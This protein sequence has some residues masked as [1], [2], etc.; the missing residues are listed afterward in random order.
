MTSP[1]D[2]AEPEPD[3]LADLDELAATAPDLHDDAVALRP[4]TF[5]DVEAITAACQDPEIQ[6][7]TTVPSPYGLDDARGFVDLCRLAW[8]EALAA[9]FL[10][11]RADDPTV[12]LGAIDL[13]HTGPV[14]AEVGYWVAPR[15]RRQGVARRAMVLLCD[16]AFA[17]LDKHVLTLQVYDGND[18]S[19]AV[20]E[21]AGFHHAGEIVAEHRGAAQPAHLYARL[22]PGR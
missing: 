6:R 16:W 17:R 11:V 15:A 9:P 22:A 21:G 20:D 18:A 10:I 1:A 14:T 2:G 19:V 5:A 13:R 3:G 12:V 4:P 8:R 7:W